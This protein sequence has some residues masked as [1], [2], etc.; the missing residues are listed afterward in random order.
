[1]SASTHPVTASSPVITELGYTGETRSHRCQKEKS[2]DI[3]R[4]HVPQSCRKSHGTVFLIS[5]LTAP[6][7]PRECRGKQCSLM[8]FASVQ[9]LSTFSKMTESD[10]RPLSSRQTEGKSFSGFSDQGL[11]RPTSRSGVDSIQV[12]RSQCF[13]EMSGLLDPPG[14]RTRPLHPYS[15]E[16]KNCWVWGHASNT[17][18]A[19]SRRN[20]SS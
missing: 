17:G 14:F 8:C 16:G 12:S 15:P 10:P 3:R 6:A 20:S 4:K 18:V 11:P 2:L 19:K 1:M 7:A 13:P 9:F 5:T